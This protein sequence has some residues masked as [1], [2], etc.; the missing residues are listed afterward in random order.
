MTSFFRSL[1]H[2]EYIRYIRVMADEDSE[3]SLTV[4]SDNMLNEITHLVPKHSLL[5]VSGQHFYFFE[6]MTNEE[7]DVTFNLKTVLSND[8]DDLK[9]SEVLGQIQNMVKFYYASN[10]KEVEARKYD[11]EVKATNHVY[12]NQ[13]RF[14]MVTKKGYTMIVVKATIGHGISY[15][16]ELSR[17]NSK[18]LS[19]DHE[20][21]DFVRTHSKKYYFIQP[22]A[23]DEL[24][25]V[26]VHRCLGNIEAKYTFLNGV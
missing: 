15:S 14:N 9:F 23:A 17:F 16:L 26:R 6:S 10:L 12:S 8:Q 2:R 24:V 22:Y 11:Y 5:P 1:F 19:E 18:K 7:I 4:V 20:T 25:K 13:L 21:V 3:Y